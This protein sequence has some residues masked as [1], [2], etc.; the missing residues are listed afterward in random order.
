MNEQSPCVY[1]LLLENNQ[2]Y[3]G[4]TTDIE[5]RLKQHKRGK[6]SGIKYCK[7]KKLALKQNCGSISQAKKLEYRLKRFKNRRII[8]KIINDGYTKIKV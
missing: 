6:T 8:Q 4:S 2:Y 1:V 3:I 5:K 7:P